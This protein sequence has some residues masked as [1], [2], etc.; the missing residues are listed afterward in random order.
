M[1][2]YKSLVQMSIFSHVGIL[3][4]AQAQGQ[5]LKVGIDEPLSFCCFQAFFLSSHFAHSGVENGSFI[6]LMVERMGRE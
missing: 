4:P 5:S 3:K 1:Y 2:L 6:I